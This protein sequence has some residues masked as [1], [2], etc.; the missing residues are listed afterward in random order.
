MSLSVQS[1]IELIEGFK[2]RNVIITL[3]GDKLGVRAPKGVLSDEDKRLL[4]LNKNQI[5]AH[6]NGS[7]DPNELFPLT[8]IQTAYWVGRQSSV[9]GGVGCHAYREFELGEIDLIRLQD[10]W[11]KVVSRHEMLRV[12]FTDDGRQRVLPSVPTYEF[13]ITDASG[14]DDAPAHRD[15]VRATMSHHVFHPGKW[16]L[17]DIRVTQLKEV[18]H[19]HMGIDLLIAD[20]ASIL[21]IYR[22]WQHFYENLDVE[23]P[24][25][26]RKF[27]DFVRT[28]EPDADDVAGAE[29]Y[30]RGRLSELPGPPQLPLSALPSEIG[31]PRFTRRT[32]NLDASRWASVSANARAAGMTPSTL[33]LSIYADVLAAFSKTQHFLIN[34]TTFSAPD[35][36]AG[37]VGDFTSTLLVEVNGRLP[38]FIDRALKIQQS[39]VAGLEHDGWSGVR[40]AR[41]RARLNN[42]IDAAIPVVFTSVVGHQNKN[43]TDKP[44]GWLGESIYSITQTPQVWID[45][46]V[47]EDSQG[48]SLSFDMVEQLFSTDLTGS[49]IESYQSMLLRVSGNDVEDAWQVK[50]GDHLPRR[51]LVERTSAN[52]TAR[53]CPERL[54]ITGLLSIEKC[55]PAVTDAFG[56]V[57]FGELRTRAASVAKQ[58]RAGKLEPGSLVG[59]FVP[60]SNLQIVAVL[61]ALLADMAY[62]PIPAGSPELRRNRLIEHGNV[63]IV[64]TGRA[65]SHLSWPHGVSHLYVDE[66]DPIEGQTTTPQASPGDLAYVIFTSGSSGEPKGVMIEHQT[67][68]NTLEDINRRFCITSEDKVLGLSDLGF[69][70]SVYDIFGLL[71]IGGHLILPDPERIRDPGHWSHLLREHRVTVWNSVPALASMLVEHN[72]GIYPD[73]KLFL[74]SGDW[75]PV[76]LP[77]K[78]RR[79]APNARI[80]ALGGATEAS[81]WSNYFDTANLASDAT[82]VPYGWPLA[83]QRLHVLNEALQ[84]CPTGVTGGLYIAGKGLAR[85]YLADA[86]LTETKFFNHPDTGERLY[87]TGDLGR[88]LAGGAIEFLGRE[89][90]Q[91]KIGGYRIE[92]GEVEAALTGHP[93]VSEATAFVSGKGIEGRR[94]LACVVTKSQSGSDNSPA[95]GSDID[96]GILST[97][98]DR[99]G[100][101]LK[102]QIKR[103]FGDKNQRVK[104]EG[105]PVLGTPERRSVRQY[106]ATT[107]RHD[108]MAHLMACLGS[109]AGRDGPLYRYPSAGNTYP[110]RA[111]LHVKPGRCSEMSGLYMYD[112]GEHELECVSGACVFPIDAHAKFNRNMADSAAFAIYLVVDMEEIVPL[113]GNLSRDFCQIETGAMCQLLME[114]AGRLE[115]GLCLTGAL[116][117][118]DLASTMALNDNRF[119]AM[120]LVGGIPGDNSNE[121]SVGSGVSQQLRSHLAERLPGYMVPERI[122]I[123]DKIPLTANGK[124]D[125][126]ALS[127]LSITRDQVATEIADGV[128][129]EAVAV[130]FSE[131][132]GRTDIGRNEVVFDLG[133]TSIH[134]VRIHNMIKQR[135]QTQLDIVDIFRAPTVAGIAAQV[136]TTS[137]DTKAV[138]AGNTRGAMRRR[139]KRER[140]RNGEG[141]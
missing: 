43:E 31:A 56:T 102:H 4:A 133:G 91:V 106:S 132:L 119:L 105:M 124:V 83:N 3:K 115:L 17:F 36:Y 103:P 6:L 40:V 2:N 135:F 46:H 85:G 84:A 18:S 89:D 5:V 88:Y 123:I 7:D 137:A 1:M 68:C 114:Q 39:L 70:L 129:E 59:I 41:E 77:D 95:A 48:L 126:N 100:F 86:T 125:R 51:D 101:R 75:V 52:D 12:V 98:A 76:D 60:K 111:W 136:A 67:A 131:V 92:L 14:C 29:K 130:I 104:L 127:K 42:E 20:A 11:N 108:T 19:L 117:S 25:P 71:G 44:L 9:L 50:L 99:L 49:I 33:L 34:L 113:Y 53:D 116:D 66:C 10:A 120:T 87:S 110:V 128:V 141:S 112:P 139:P 93:L 90:A 80:I 107:I 97:T 57:S 47:I 23:L 73:L 109:V 54:L 27:S 8:E 37:V 32:V 122:V 61:G 121:A 55:R 64:L 78:L 79:I 21:M 96:P 81:I 16:P 26:D 82:S 58:L 22:E 38:S 62:L 15:Q 134:I 138:D 65:N 35:G 24:L 74:L 72:D 63:D 30:W 118:T 13:S 45:H 140:R 94:L 28:G 69:D